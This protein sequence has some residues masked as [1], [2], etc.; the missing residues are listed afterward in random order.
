MRTCV[1]GAVYGCDD[2][3]IL[4]AETTKSGRVSGSIIYIS[5]LGDIVHSTKIIMNDYGK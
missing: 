1:I 4:C 3:P 2:E 5:I